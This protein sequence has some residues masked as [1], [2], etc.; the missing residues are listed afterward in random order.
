MKKLELNEM[1]SFLAGDS[2]TRNCFLR[3]VGIGVSLLFGLWPATIAIA[4]TSS[5]CFEV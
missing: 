1:E 5:H 3:G 4:A 2:E